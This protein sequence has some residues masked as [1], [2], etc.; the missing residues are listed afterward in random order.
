MTLEEFRKLADTWGGNI[1]RWPD[2]TKSAAQRLGTTPEGAEVLKQAGRL[3]AFL[4]SRPIIRKERAQRAAYAVTLQIA[5]DSERQRQ[6]GAR[7]QWHSWFVP[8]ASLACSALVGILLAM[9]T[10]ESNQEVL[11]LSLLLDTGS[12]SQGWTLQ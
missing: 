12:I 5:T 8:A 4:A 11:I 6:A 9:L 7:R 3:D 2:A 1:E 10:P